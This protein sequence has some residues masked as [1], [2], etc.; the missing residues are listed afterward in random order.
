MF[1]QVGVALPE[2]GTGV[3]AGPAVSPAPWEAWSDGAR[4]SRTTNESGPS[5]WESEAVAVSTANCGKDS[6]A[7]AP[8]TRVRSNGRTWVPGEPELIAQAEG[9]ER[10]ATGCGLPTM[11]GRGD[12]GRA[13][14]CAAP[15]ASP[16]PGMR[17]STATKAT[18]IR[19]AHWSL[20]HAMCG[21]SGSSLM[22]LKPAPHRLALPGT[23]QRKSMHRA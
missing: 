11:A 3:I 16:C 14:E 22:N 19:L 13:R 8:F 7:S 5:P 10:R 21:E 20:P 12:C 4:L 15:I 1:D 2:K 6:P 18:A 9:P 17:K 23:S